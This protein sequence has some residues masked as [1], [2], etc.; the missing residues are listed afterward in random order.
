MPS[1]SSFAFSQAV[2]RIFN[3]KSG[4]EPIIGSNFAPEKI[5]SPSVDDIIRLSKE[6]IAWAQDQD[7][8]AG[9]QKYRELQTSSKGAMPLRHLA[10]LAIHGE[11]ER[12]SF[13]KESFINGDRLGFVPYITINML[14][15]ALVIA[16]EVCFPIYQ[17]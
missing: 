7:I 17:S 2:D 1:V 10:A 14:E 3:E 16:K 13:Y 6:T 12:L 9:L 15:E 4:Y 5:A 11:V 8:E